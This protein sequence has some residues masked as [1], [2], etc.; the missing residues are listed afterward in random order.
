MRFGHSHLRPGDQSMLT[1]RATLDQIAQ[2]VALLKSAR[3]RRDAT[4]ADPRMNAVFRH[5]VG[6][7]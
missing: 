7:P 6:E 3:A 1:C 4:E 2:T 5:A